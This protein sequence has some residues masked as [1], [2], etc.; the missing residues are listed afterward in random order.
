MTVLLV[1]IGN[2]RIKW[3]F[4]R[5]GKL[6]DCGRRA[7][8]GRADVA[9]AALRRAIAGER[10]ELATVANV[11]GDR[12]E[13]RIFSVLA[14]HGAVKVRFARV[15]RNRRGVRCGYRD[16]S[17]LGVDRWVSV[18]AAHAMSG[19][20]AIVVDVGTTLTVDGVTADGVHL[21][22]LIVPGARLMA[23]ALGQRTSDIGDVPVSPPP[24]SRGEEYLGR[25]T[26]EAVNMG[27]WAALTGVVHKVTEHLHNAIPAGAPVFV[28]GGDAEVLLG[29]LGRVARHRPHL[30][31]EG[32]A[33]FAGRSIDLPSYRKGGG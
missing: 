27:S 18:L 30:V 15:G 19:R 20:G 17:R 21:G 8:G 33:L 4:L 10:L 16:P 11:A 26:A 28:T 23:A 32:L 14:K 31:L 2:T 7:H 13:S 6:T 1:D 3:G 24:V 22:G 9:G 5:A 25:S 12:F 29:Q